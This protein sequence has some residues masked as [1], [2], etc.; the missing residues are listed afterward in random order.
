[1]AEAINEERLN[2]KI[3]IFVL[4]LLAVHVSPEEQKLHF[5]PVFDTEAD[6]TQVGDSNVYITGNWVAMDEHSKLPGVSMSEITCARNLKLCQ[7]LQGNLVV[8][9]NMFSLVPDS[10]DYNV[11]RWDSEEIMAT[12]V[13]GAC[14][15]ANSLKFDR[16]NKKVYALE[17]L[18]VPL[19]TL[20]QALRA[21]CNAAAGSRWELHGKTMYWLGSTLNK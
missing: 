19:D 18:S 5:S 4:L 3:A 13:G 10:K 20:T 17:S 7:E 2:M 21:H 12:S 15:M 14:K 8:Q 1:L 16:K 9:G 6:F 11:V